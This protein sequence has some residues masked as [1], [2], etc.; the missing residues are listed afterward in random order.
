[1]QCFFFQCLSVFQ[2]LFLVSSVEINLWLLVKTIQSVSQDFEILT[3]FW[4]STPIS[5]KVAFWMLI[6]EPTI[7]PACWQPCSYPT[8]VFGGETRKNSNLLGSIYVLGLLLKYCSDIMDETGYATASFHCV[9]ESN[10]IIASSIGMRFVDP[11]FR[12]CF[13]VS[14][15]S[16]TEKLAF[17]FESLF[18]Y[19]W[20]DFG[21]FC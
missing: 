16:D 1:M 10:W 11:W 2:L 8:C 18:D 21:V 7:R 13:E 3:V 9:G 12:F 15:C 5:A 20:I 14:F 17:G 19:E 6:M 4:C